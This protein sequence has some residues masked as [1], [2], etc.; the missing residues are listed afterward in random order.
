[1]IKKEYEEIPPSIE[2]DKYCGK[3]VARVMPILEKEYSFEKDRMTRIETKSSIELQMYKIISLLGTDVNKI[4]VDIGCGSDMNPDSVVLPFHTRFFEPWLCRALH[5]I[6]YSPIGVDIGV[7]EEKFTYLR[8]NLVVYRLKDIGDSSVDC[9]HAHG[10]FDS[11]VFNESGGNE[12]VR[13]ELEE[14]FKI[15]LKPEGFY[16]FEE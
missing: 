11:P 1:M 12:Q 2:A 10:F 6:G 9:I 3:L 14:T 16:I 4:I 8:K 5:H 15:K 7:S 13:R